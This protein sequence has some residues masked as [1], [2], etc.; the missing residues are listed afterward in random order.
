[1]CSKKTEDLNL[2]VFNMI[3]WINESEILTKHISCNCECKFDGTICNLN[4]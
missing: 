4:Q 2:R 1:M 3:I